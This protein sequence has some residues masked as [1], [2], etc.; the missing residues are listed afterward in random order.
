MK[1]AL[2]TIAAVAFVSIGS[3]PA[4]AQVTIFFDNLDSK[5][6]GS[7]A[8][9]YTFGDVA[10]A[11]RTY[12]S[13][14]VGGSVAA[15]LQSD[16]TAPG[17]GYG[18]EAFQY[19]LGNVGGANTSANLSSYT[20]SFD[21]SVNKAGGGFSLTFQDWANPGFSGAMGSSTDPT[22]HTIATP[23]SFQHFSINL[24]NFTNGSTPANPAG[25]TWQIAFQ[26][27]EFTFGTA[28]TTGN[29][30]I[31]DN[32]GI[33]MAP[34]PSCLALGAFGLLALF[35]FRKNRQ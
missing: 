8:P 35:R 26:M 25:Q 31:I 33:T 24:G 20:L 4:T 29:Q 9:G 23:N 28:P 1:R 11:T 5:T 18:G 30:L 15:L 21:A 27:D 10:N 2:K 16:F 32:V 12:Q 14:G 7:T 34:E 22:E 3:L 13:V 17:V 19:Q 6:V